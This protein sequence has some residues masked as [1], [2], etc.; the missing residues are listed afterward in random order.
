MGLNIGSVNGADY[1]KIIDKNALANVTEKILNPDNEKTVDV[2]SLN[3]SKFNRVNIGTDLYSGKTDF[4]VALQAAKAKTDFDVNLSQGF[5]SK[6]QYLNSVAA[7]SMFTS[8]ENTGK[9]VI[10]VDNFQNVNENEIIIET[11]HI[12]DTKELSKDKRGS[13]PFA[14]YV[15]T[16]SKEKKED[17]ETV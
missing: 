4:D 8:K 9:V 17:N 12:S 10:S 7:Q 6:V 11:S 2:A 15:P 1:S 14:F 5:N 16:G 13:N 3:L